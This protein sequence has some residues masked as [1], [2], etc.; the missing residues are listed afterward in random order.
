MRRIGRARTTKHAIHAPTG[1]LRGA[2]RGEA[3]TTTGERRTARRVGT[4]IGGSP[5]LR[6]CQRRP[7]CRRT[8]IKSHLLDP[9]H[10]SGRAQLRHGGT[11]P[12][13]GR[14]AARTPTTGTSSTDDVGDRS[15]EELY[16]ALV[17]HYRTAD[18]APAGHRARPRLH[19]D[20][21][22]A[23]LVGR[24]ATRWSRSS[25][26]TCRSSSTRSSMELTR[27][28]RDV[29]LVIHPQFDVT[30]D[31]TGRLETHRL[32][33]QRVRRAA[34]RAP[35]A[36][37]GCTSRSAGSATTRT[38][39]RSPRDV[40][41]V[42]R[43]VRESVEDWDRMRQQAGGDRRRAARRP[44]RLD[45]RRG[46]RAG[47][48]PSS[49]WL[50]RRPLHLPRLPRVPPRARR[51]RATTSAACPAPAYGILRNDPDMSVVVRQAAAQGRRDGPR[52]HPAGAGQGQLPLDRA[53]PGVPRLR[54]RED[55]RRRRAR[56]S[57]SAGSSAS[58]PARPTPSRSGRIPLLRETAR[59]TC[60][61][62][63]GLDPHSHAGKALI[64]TLETYPRDE[65]FHTPVDELAADG[66]AR[67][68]D[69]RAPPAAASSYAATPTAATSAC[70]VFL[71]R[72]R[73]N[74]S[75]P[76]AVLRDP[77]GRASAASPSSSPSG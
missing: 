4:P 13:R 36:S 55:V 23:R 54:R 6:L 50:C 15:A 75:G 44:A 62:R 5:N 56:S 39:T 53:P 25:P 2:S 17:S 24:R 72:D 19:P 73:Y 51:A 66:H 26:T 32:P 68:G 14:P 71:P 63:V 67:H 38:S 41:R 33:R 45:L 30:R 34:A 59:R 8:P 58:S 35:S 43:D 40:Q 42:L 11:A 27:Q 3:P 20:P 70:L 7:P 1:V 10:C 61:D 28:Q 74:T 76:R 31:V 47:R 64:D 60:S 69:P 16:G 29:H 22:R 52:A 57:A 48:A 46:A 49:S 18:V 77:Q 65:L 37:R 9:G 12:R 21:G